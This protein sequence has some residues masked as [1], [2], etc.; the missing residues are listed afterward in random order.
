[1]T[2][3][4]TPNP[5]SE[6]VG[7][8]NMAS[9]SKPVLAPKSAMGEAVPSVPVRTPVGAREQLAADALRLW[10][11]DAQLAMMVEECAEFIQAVMHYRRGR[12]D[13]AYVAQ[14]VADVRIMMDQA[15]WLFGADTCAEAERHKRTRLYARL[16]TSELK[17]AQGGAP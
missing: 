16:E 2:R 5:S 15:A 1:M 11:A 12:V 8:E 7:E 9:Q 13:A 4:M 14:E 3:S 6:R 17:R 10:G